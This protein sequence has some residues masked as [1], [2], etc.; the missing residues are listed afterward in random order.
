MHVGRAL[1]TWLAWDGKSDSAIHKGH[2]V[3][4][5]HAGVHRHYNIVGNIVSEMGRS[6][7]G[8]GTQYR[9]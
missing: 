3:C 2:W 4:N 8:T 1:T 5:C 7:Y 9:S 6:D